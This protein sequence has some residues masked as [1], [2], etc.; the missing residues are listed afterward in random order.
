MYKKSVL[1]YTQNRWAFGQ[2]HHA[3]I[4]RLWNFGYYC[5]LLDWTVGYSELEWQFFKLK[6]NIFVT[7][8]EA[9]NSLV[10]RG[11][12]PERIVTIAHAEKDIVGGIA[13]A[14][15]HLFDKVLSFAVVNKDLVEAS[16][17][18]GVTRIPEV[19]T[20]GIDFDH[21]YLNRSDKL[22]Y[23]GYAGELK[24]ITAQQKDCK[25][26]HLVSEVINK[27]GISF[28]QHQF[29]NHLAMAG[30]Y[31]TV[32]AIICPSNSETAG[33]PNMEAAAAGRLVM[34]T[35]VGYFD[36]AYGVLLSMDEQ[37]LVEDATTALEKYKDPVLYTEVCE[38]SQ[39]YS[40]DN[41]DWSH[42]IQGWVN[43]LN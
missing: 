33:L 42:H 24:H 39:Q 8:P 32:D 1:F 30:Y 27:S 37:K 31:S 38:K 23:L 28:R 40:K 43:L 36:G 35:P 34:S 14:G 7:T 12:A 19:V 16:K 10:C 13:S 26:A 6:F 20:V 5:H 3:L 2:I 29:F 17:K 22:T 4:K 21:Y 9:V 15:T 25:R 41:H 11:I 18:L